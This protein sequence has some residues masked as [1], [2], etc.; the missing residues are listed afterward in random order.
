MSPE[1]IY[2]GGAIVSAMLG[3]YWWWRVTLFMDVVE[4][5]LRDIDRNIEKLTRGE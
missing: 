3:A 4:N 2:I 5:R 1:A